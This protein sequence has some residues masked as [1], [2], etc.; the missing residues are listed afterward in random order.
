[1]TAMVLFRSRSCSLAARWLLVHQQR[2]AAA[3]GVRRIDWGSMRLR[4]PLLVF[5]RRLGGPAP[6]AHTAVRT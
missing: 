4:L 5:A 6:M 3:D 1:M 2:F